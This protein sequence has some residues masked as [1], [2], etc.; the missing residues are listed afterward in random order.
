MTRSLFQTELVQDRVMTRCSSTDSI[1]SG[2]SYNEKSF[3]KTT[4]VENRD[5]T[6]SL[7]RKARL[8]QDRVMMVGRELYHSAMWE[9]ARQIVTC[10]A[11]SE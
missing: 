1:S 2:Q 7:F 6:R 10:Q 11:G 9:N 8:C 4:L 3:P 5:A